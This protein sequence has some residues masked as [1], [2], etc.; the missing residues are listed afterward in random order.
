MRVSDDGNMAVKHIDGAPSNSTAYQEFYATP[1]IL[2]HSSNVLQGIGSA[3]TIAQGGATLV[4]TKPNSKWDK[5]RK[6]YKTLYKADISN[7]DLAR[8]GRGDHSFNACSANTS[9]FLGVL[10]SEP[11]DPNRLE[12]RRN[13]I[14]KL[15]G[16]IDHAN[17][18]IN[19]GEDIGAALVEAR[20]IVTGENTSGEAKTAYN[21]MWEAMRGWISWRY[22]VNESAVPDVGEAWAIM[23]GGTGGRSGMGHF[24]PVVAKSGSDSV[25]LENDVSQTAGQVRAQIGDLNPNWYMRMF[26]PVKR[27]LFSANEDQTFWGEAKKNESADYGDRPLVGR[28]GSA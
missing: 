12:Q 17:K 21:E 13:I 4:G 18:Q 2:Q 1:A 20:K 23:Q 19:V 26:G 9:N 15:E 6:N 5:W 27:H 14:L 28:L 25:T 16:A 3:F 11:G 24:A 7:Q 22:G 10:R 8:T